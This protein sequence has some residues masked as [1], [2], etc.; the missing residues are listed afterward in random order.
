MD[1][2]ELRN[3]MGHF[4]TGVTVITCDTEDGTHGIT[5]NSFTSVSLDP[6]L[7]LVSIDRKAKALQHLKNNNF[8]VNILKEDQEDIAMHFA[9][10]PLDEPTFQLQ[11]GNLSTRLKDTLAYVECEPWAEYDGGDHVLYVGKVSDFTYNP[12][13]PLA[14]YCG[15]FSDVLPK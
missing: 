13:R 9:G 11:K 5:A 7:V 3:C 1:S 15:K 2:R 14:Y 12:G 4:A 6:P 8:T 10:R